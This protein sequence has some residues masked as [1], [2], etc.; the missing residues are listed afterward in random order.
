MTSTNLGNLNVGD[1][2]PVIQQITPSPWQ[3]GAPPFQ[4]AIDGLHF[5]ATQWKAFFPARVVQEP[6]ILLSSQAQP[7]DFH[8]ATRPGRGYRKSG[9]VRRMLCERLC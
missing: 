6:S 3:A 4:V 8:R 5:G 9:V 7:R 1:A 2:T